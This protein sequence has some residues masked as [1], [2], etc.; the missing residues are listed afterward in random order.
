[1]YPLSHSVV[2]FQSKM[3]DSSGQLQSILHKWGQWG[4][5]VGGE[6]L[7]RQ[8]VSGLGLA[9]CH[10]YKVCSSIVYYGLRHTCFRIDR[11][12]KGSSCGE[13]GHVAHL[14]H[15]QPAV[16]AHQV[17]VRS[18]HHCYRDAV[19][20]ELIPWP[21]IILLCIAGILL[22]FVISGYMVRIYRGITSP[23]V[24]DTWVSLYI[25][26]IKLAIVGFC[27]AASCPP[28]H[29]LCLYHDRFR[30]RV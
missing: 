6:V 2:I 21:R 28:D 9:A 11:V 30:G 7:V 8:S 4:K 22:S 19:H 17:R 25:D 24:F 10:F 20:W 13:L 29:S 27:L 18:E 15:L 23:P 5:N 1:M 16:C 26:G 12:H 3:A 14:H